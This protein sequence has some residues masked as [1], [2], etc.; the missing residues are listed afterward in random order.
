MLL[1]ERS[2]DGSGTAGV[3][4]QVDLRLL[5]VDPR[6]RLDQLPFRFPTLTTHARPCS[7]QT[8]SAQGAGSGGGSRE[9]RGELCGRKRAEAKRGRG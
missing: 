4:L 2:A 7:A 9:V 6:L 5:A 1:T 8:A 3:C